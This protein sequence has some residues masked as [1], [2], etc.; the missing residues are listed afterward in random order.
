[1]DS[2][3]DTEVSSL[4]LVELSVDS[5][6]VEELALL[7]DVESE[8]SVDSEDE[9]EDVVEVSTEDSEE[10]LEEVVDVELSPPAEAAGANA[11]DRATARAA[12]TAAT[13]RAK[14]LLRK[15]LIRSGCCVFAFMAYLPSWRVC[16]I[17]NASDA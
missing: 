13:K 10:S 2:V 14:N 11:T 4:E 7:V 12:A 15:P 5:V 6:T 3:E 8:V 9:S 16:S 17:S 1:M